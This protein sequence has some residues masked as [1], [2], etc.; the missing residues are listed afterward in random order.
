[1]LSG[2][3]IMNFKWFLKESKKFMGYGVS[4]PKMLFWLRFPLAY[5]KFEYYQMKAKL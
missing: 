2:V 5:I 3:K 1:M 4:T